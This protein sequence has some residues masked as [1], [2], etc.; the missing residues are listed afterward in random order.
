MDKKLKNAINTYAS[1]AVRE[2][3]YLICDGT[4]WGSAKDGFY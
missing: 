3:V 2:K 4:V 1:G